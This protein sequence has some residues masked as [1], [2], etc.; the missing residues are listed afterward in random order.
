MV[1]A[2]EQPECQLESQPPQLLLSTP[3]EEQAQLLAPVPGSCLEMRFEVVALNRLASACRGALG[4][5]IQ[6]SWL[7]QCSRPSASANQHAQGKN[8]SSCCLLQLPQIWVL[9]VD[10]PKPQWD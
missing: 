10:L 4:Q 1:L 7:Q 9:E 5:G 6:A 8:A 3:L 2:S